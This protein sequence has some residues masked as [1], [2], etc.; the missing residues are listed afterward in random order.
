MSLSLTKPIAN[1]AV[2]PEFEPLPAFA[3][4]PHVP[5]ADKSRKRILYVDDDAQIR[6]LGERILVLSGFDVDTAEDGI[7]AWAALHNQ[8]YQLL[9]TDHQMPRLTGWELV[10]KVRLSRM[11][12]PVILASAALDT[13]LVDDFSLLGCEA[14]LAKPFTAQQLLSAVHE[15]LGATLRTGR[16]RGWPKET[17]SMRR[18]A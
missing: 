7:D 8:D 6:I 5:A 9:I 13:L 14:T 17:D 10:R 1:S 18:R 16:R 3:A 2:P 4:S 15:A 12:V 11:S